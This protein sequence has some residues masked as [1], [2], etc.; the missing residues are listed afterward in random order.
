MDLLGNR[1]KSQDYDD[2]DRALANKV[3][4]CVCQTFKDVE[5]R[6]G[7]DVGS[8]VFCLGFNDIKSEVTLLFLQNCI[9][10][11]QNLV[12]DLRIYY[13]AGCIVLQFELVRNRSK[14]F[15]FP[16]YKLLSPPNAIVNDFAK[17]LS[18]SWHFN[19]LEDSRRVYQLCFLIYNSERVLPPIETIIVPNNRT[20][21]FEGVEQPVCDIQFTHM[22]SLRYSFLETVFERVGPRLCN[23]SIIPTH[24][25]AL[26]VRFWL[27]ARDPSTETKP[28]IQRR[29][30]ISALIG[31][32]YKKRKLEQ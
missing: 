11:G 2:E 5:C 10:A 3:A 4:A 25:T 17:I 8:P 22:D 31:E 18:T 9:R 20:E 30:K 1:M 27:L 12:S 21:I 6:I 23:L 32:G 29:P 28:M 13:L 26:D 7:L 15:Y 19:R 14:S 24:D 16:R